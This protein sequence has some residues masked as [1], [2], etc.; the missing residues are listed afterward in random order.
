MR[1]DLIISK[2]LIAIQRKTE[3]LHFYQK[4]AH[5]AVSQE[6]WGAGIKS[7]FAVSMSYHQGN[8]EQYMTT[9]NNGHSFP[10]LGMA[11][12]AFHPLSQTSS[13]GA[14]SSH[15]HD[16]GTNGKLQRVLRP[17]LQTNTLWLLLP[18]CLLKQITWLNPKARVW[19]VRSIQ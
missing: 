10:W 9:A 8:A 2:I 12:A 7:F 17:S 13:S 11:G 18:C 19:V 1:E 14:Q 15:T 4:M 3:A 16:S 6:E 5:S